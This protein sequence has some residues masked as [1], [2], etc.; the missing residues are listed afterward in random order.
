[1]INPEREGFAQ[2]FADIVK[3]DRLVKLFRSIHEA[4]K[5]AQP[6]S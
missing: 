6:S 2:V 4:R 5:W 1:M 3:C